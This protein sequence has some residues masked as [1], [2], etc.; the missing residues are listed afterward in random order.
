MITSMLF[1]LNVYL[2]NNNAKADGLT[3]RVTIPQS[4]ESF[5]LKLITTYS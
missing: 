4:K 2:W 5:K 1:F 3:L